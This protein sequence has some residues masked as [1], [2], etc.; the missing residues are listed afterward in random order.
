MRST[1]FPWL[2]G[3]LVAL[4]GALLLALPLSFPIKLLVACL[5]VFLTD[6]FGGRWFGYASVLVLFVGL[7]RDPNGQWATMLP[8]VVGSA[9]A[10]LLVRHSERTW[11]GVLLSM[12]AFMLPVGL[13]Q[14]IRPRFDPALQM[15]LGS[16][17][18]VLHLLASSFA[19]L[20]SSL[21]TWQQLSPTAATRPT[22]DPSRKT[23]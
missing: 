21:L 11:F 15:P 3:V 9:L 20:V 14:V 12:G 16:R 1:V 8:L 18:V 6:A 13:M 4:S 10:A 22:P 19:I 5:T 17:Y 23:S 2:S 7:S